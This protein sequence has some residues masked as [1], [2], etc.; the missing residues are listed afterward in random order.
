MVHRASFDSSTTAV[1]L[2]PTLPIRGASLLGYRCVYAE[3]DSTL[4]LQLSL[5]LPCRGASLLGYRRV[6]LTY[7][8]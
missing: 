5:I 6:S 1:A 8:P 3:P 4:A 7:R 2:P